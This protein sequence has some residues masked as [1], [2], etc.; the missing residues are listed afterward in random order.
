MGV[1]ASANTEPSRNFVPES[2]VRKPQKE[3]V[4][5][6]FSYP[7]VPEFMKHWEFGINIDEGEGPQYFADL[8]LPLYRPDA[9]DR[10]LF[11]EPRIAHTDSQ[12]LLNLGLG[13]RR[14]IWDRSWMLGGN[15]FFDYETEVD[16]YRLGLGLEAISAYAELRANGYFGL[17]HARTTLPGSASDDTEKA[18]DG[19]DLELGFPVPY[20]SRLKF[21]GGYEWYDFK[22][23][24]NRRGWWARAA[25][26]PTPAVILDVSLRDNNKQSTAW[27]LT[28]AFRPPFW[29]NSL[30]ETRSPFKLDQVIFPDSDVSDKLYIPVERHH[31]I[32]VESYKQAAGQATI[33]ITRNN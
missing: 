27:G 26:T 15:T 20:Y 2:K 24:D 30:K 25:Y 19:Y 13:Y 9:E 1:T 32:V 28:V 33:E 10:T 16:H 18:V 8:I 5:L 21:F 12:T 14:F 17:S 7:Q 29:E 22:Q 31:E 11:V 6:N 23:F 3:P 4:P